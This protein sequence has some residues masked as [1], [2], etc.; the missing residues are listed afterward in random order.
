MTRVAVFHPGRQHSWQTVRALQQA[1]ALAWYATALFYRAD[2]WPY[3]I[4]PLL[5]AVLRRPVSRYFAKV[6]CPEIDAR[7][8]RIVGAYEWAERLAARSNRLGAAEL[9]NRLGN[10]RFQRGVRRLLEREPAAAVWGYD[11]SC[12]DVFEFAGRRGALCILDRSIGHPR[13]LREILERE[14]ALHPEFFAG[15]LGMPSQAQIEEADREIALADH[16]VVGSRFSADTVVASGAAP[17]KLRIVPYGYEE[18]LFG[19]SRPQRPE[20]G[21][22][23][24]RFLFVGT[25]SPRK[26]VHHL[27]EAF[28][29]IP[30]EQA[31]L[32]VVGPSAIPQAVLARYRPHVEFTGALSRAEVARQF[33][34]AHCFIFPSL[35]EGGGIVLY[36]AVASGLGVVHSA[37]TADLATPDGSNGLR[38]D[39]VDAGSIEAAV[40]QI[41]ERPEILRSWADAAWAMRSALGW[42]SYRRRIAQLLPVLLA[43][44]GAG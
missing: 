24:V 7:S 39:R 4:E 19:A 29:R 14:R 36:E 2:R 12:A 31:V 43:R 40:R 26:G 28:R 32:T 38:L 10:R 44:S 6:A 16:I 42:Q 5:P 33:E 3:R 18:Q 13:A 11:T 23:P 15:D 9:L 34:R 8:V 21:R 30:R 35:F 22:L 27:L 41:L 37:A 20:L 17:A 1:E 25:V